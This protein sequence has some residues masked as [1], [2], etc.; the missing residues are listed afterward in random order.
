MQAEKEEK[1]KKKKKKEERERKGEGKREKGGRKEE[2][3]ESGSF[4]SGIDRF[5]AQFTWIFL[6]DSTTPQAKR[7]PQQHL[8]YL[9]NLTPSAN[10]ST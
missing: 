2:E 4:K 8:P 9:A 3:S 10:P 1:N 6:C 5:L 7:Q